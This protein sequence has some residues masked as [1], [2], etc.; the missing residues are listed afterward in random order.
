MNLLMMHVIFLT[1]ISL[2]FLIRTS[3]QL[4]SLGLLLMILSL[5]LLKVK[6]KILILIF[7]YLLYLLFISQFC[8]FILCVY[9]F[10]R[11][12]HFGGNDQKKLNI[13]SNEK[14][15]AIY[16]S[17]LKRSV[18]G[19]LKWGTTQA[20]AAE[21]S[22]NIRSAQRIWKRA[23]DTLS[24]G[25]LDVSHLKTKNYNR[26]RIQFDPQNFWNIPLSQQ[27]TLRSTAYAMKI[28]T[29]TLFRHYKDYDTRRR[30]SNSIKSLWRIKI[31]KIT[32]N[33]A[34]QR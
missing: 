30:L 7:N 17:P 2:H 20:I 18:N 27:T 1:W 34:C 6:F 32:L 13:L 33:F 14:R 29:S 16:L 28:S 26:K 15:H 22:V 19:R 3:L 9:L 4:M 10:F 31:W 21:F 24:R 5:F 25:K 11:W 23:K 12:K 8:L